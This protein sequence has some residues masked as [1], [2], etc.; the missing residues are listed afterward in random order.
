[1]PHAWRSQRLGSAPPESVCHGRK[2]WVLLSQK[3]ETFAPIPLC[4]IP[5]IRWLNPVSWDPQVY[6]GTLKVSR[7]LAKKTHFLNPIFP[8]PTGAL[9]AAPERVVAAS[10]WRTRE[11][12]RPRQLPA[13]PGPPPIHRAGRHP[14]RNA[15]RSRWQGDRWRWR[16]A[17]EAA[18]TERFK[19]RKRLSAAAAAGAGPGFA[20]T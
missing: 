15:A 11:A 3:L 19:P 16:S 7:L 5:D 6:P 17:S 2:E 13:A 4:P 10:H 18:A 8:F 9:A 14:L 12:D 1:M 20:H